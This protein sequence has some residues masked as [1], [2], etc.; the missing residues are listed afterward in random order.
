M[1]QA[2]KDDSREQKKNDDGDTS[3]FLPTYLHNLH[4]QAE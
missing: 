3:L 2:R 4:M 1:S